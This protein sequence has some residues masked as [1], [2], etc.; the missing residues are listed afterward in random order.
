LK[1][2]K[3]L[4]FINRWSTYILGIEIPNG[5]G[6]DQRQATYGPIDGQWECDVPNHENVSYFSTLL[7]L[8]I[9]FTPN[10]T[11][12]GL[13]LDMQYTTFFSKK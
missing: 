13:I 10:N 9:D 6:D 5:L 1:A 8:V 2:L 7:V 11:G 3:S 12:T 4:I